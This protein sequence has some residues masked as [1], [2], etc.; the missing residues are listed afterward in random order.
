MRRP[1]TVA[2]LACL[3]ASCNAS[4]AS[5]G[6]TDTAGK[7]PDAAG[8]SEFTRIDLGTLGGASSYAAG[9][10]NGSVVVGWSETAKGE[11]HAF[12][13]TAAKGMVDL[14]ALPGQTSSR[15]VAIIDTKDSSEPQVLGVS[16]D[17]TNLVPVVWLASGAIASLAMPTNQ[18]L[19][20]RVPSAF[21]SRGE[22]VG[23]DVGG[24]FQHGWIWSATDGTY[25][26]SA[27]LATAAGEGNASAITSSGQV[28]LSVNT[29][30][31]TRTPQCWRTYVW[32]KAQ[33]YRDLG[34]PTAN[35]EANVTGLDLNDA[36]SV[37]G[38]AGVAPAPYRWS[39]VTGFRVL[40]Q[41]ASSNAY[42]YA[43]AVNSSGVVVGADLDP[44]VGSIVASI[45]S[46]AGR[47]SKLSA[48][49]P[50]PSV[51]VAIN[52][53]G[54]VAGWATISANSSHAVIWS[55]STRASGSSLVNP[56]SSSVRVTTKST[57]CMSSARAI[58]SRQA[59]FDCVAK[60]DRV[61]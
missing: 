12:R 42:G 32:T 6:V 7:D 22:V 24:G 31:C 48:N 54:T 51:A 53:R 61:K 28:L 11:T 33:G 3:A 47:I 57:A 59:L 1:I 2:L 56:A 60:A 39:A 37:V 36:G 45:W 23:S 18:T 50:N 21:N 16:G 10:N 29:S 26:L 46:T 49:D 58:S 5:L 19:A 13:W 9:I 8:N 43:T 41:Y 34:T 52:D 40:P 30:S 25:D 14:G 4:D 35:R 38:W 15:A 17:G 27:N 20:S 44:A 55:P